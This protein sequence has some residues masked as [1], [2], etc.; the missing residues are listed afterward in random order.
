LRHGLIANLCSAA[1]WAIDGDVGSVAEP[2]WPKP[3]GL[4]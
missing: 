3:Q 4:L 2:K 1:L